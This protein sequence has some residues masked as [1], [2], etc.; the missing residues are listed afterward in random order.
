MVI[1]VGINLSGMTFFLPFFSAVKCNDN[2]AILSVLAQLG[3]GFD[4][5][6]KVR[7]QG[8]Y[9]IVLIVVCEATSIKQ[10]CGKGRHVFLYLVGL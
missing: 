5:A 3:T 7:E 2:P 1:V 6:S 4:C 10:E 9:L 8:F